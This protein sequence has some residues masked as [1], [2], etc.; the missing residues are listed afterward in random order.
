MQTFLR[1]IHSVEFAKTFRSL[2]STTMDDTLKRLFL[3]DDIYA[4][5]KNYNGGYLK[6]YIRIKIILEFSILFWNTLI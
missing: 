1:S 5:Q 2:G 3:G 4:H 6:S